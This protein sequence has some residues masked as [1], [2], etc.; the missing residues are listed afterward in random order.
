MTTT[1]PA[2]AVAIVLLVVLG[3]VVA[4]LGRTG[5]GLAVPWASVRAAAQLVVLALV[6]GAVARRPW[7]CALFVLVMS[8]TASW[9]AAG[10]IRGRRARTGRVRRG[11]RIPWSHVRDALWCALPVSVPSVLVVLAFLATGV[12]RPTGLAVIPVTGILLGNAMTVGG[13]AGRRAHDELD[14]R[15]GEVEAALSLGLTEVD[16]RMLV[17]RE[18]AASALGPSLDQT[19]TIGLV[20]IPGA[21]VGMVLGGADPW[22]AGVMQLFVSV[23]ILALGAIALVGT[24][25]LVA[26]G[27]V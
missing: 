4:W 8:T 22:Q 15:R 9:T 19:R 7:A 1:G 23:G 3:A 10:R 6:I 25:Q 17:C 20:T 13:L 14:A 5:H 18:A 16:S 12:V 2:I 21:F 27:R 26:R 24:T 11:H